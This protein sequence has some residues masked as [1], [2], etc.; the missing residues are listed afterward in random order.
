MKNKDEDYD[1]PTFGE[2]YQVILLEPWSG[3]NIGDTV[4]VYRG[5][6]NTLL[7][8]KKAI[9]VNDYEDVNKDMKLLITARNN[10]IENKE[11]LDENI[12]LREEI[13]KLKK[14]IGKKDLE[15]KN[16]MMLKKDIRT[17]SKKKKKDR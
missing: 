2:Q 6:Y 7:N 11:L 16:K 10:E 12:K 17:K 15:Y 9:A 5:M 4:T 13:K 1:I 8:L 3:N 14:T